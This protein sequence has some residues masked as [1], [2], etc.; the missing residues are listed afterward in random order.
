[1]IKFKLSLDESLGIEDTAR[2]TTAKISAIR[3]LSALTVTHVKQAAPRIYSR[4]LVDLIFD[5]PALLP[6]SE[7]R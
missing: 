7:F 4:E 1:L 5:L 3:N 6:Y 2:W